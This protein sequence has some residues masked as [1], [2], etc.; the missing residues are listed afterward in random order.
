MH[1]IYKYITGETFCI[2]ETTQYASHSQR[3]S[4]TQRSRELISNVAAC[5][6]PESI[7][8]GSDCTSTPCVQSR[9]TRSFSSFWQSSVQFSALKR[10]C[11]TAAVAPVSKGQKEKEKGGR[12]EDSWGQ[13]ISDVRRNYFF[14]GGLFLVTTGEPGS[15][16]K[17]TNI[18]W[19]HT[20]ESTR[21][22]APWQA[23]A[24]GPV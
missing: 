12:R 16:N 20:L 19:T 22:P 23:R 13:H 2:R 17:K 9:S 24:G 21:A 15:S 1:Y 8:L 6:H 10:N 7:R 3:F 18:K 14:F 11:L 4:A 5:S